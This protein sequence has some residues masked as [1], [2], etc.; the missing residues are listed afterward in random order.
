M[1]HQLQELDG[2]WVDR[3]LARTL[4]IGW[5]DEETIYLDLF[6]SDKSAYAAEGNQCLSSMM[7][8]LRTG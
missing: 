6:D 1:V 7:L 5:E 4:H 2:F 3:Q 8:N